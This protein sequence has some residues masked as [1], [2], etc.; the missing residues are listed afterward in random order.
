MRLD[1]YVARLDRR[2]IQAVRS[3]AAM[4][5]SRPV[6]TCCHWVNWLGDGWLYLFGMAMILGTDGIAAWRPLLAACLATGFAFVPYLL[7]KPS[8]RRLR[9]CDSDPA[10][11]RGA[12]ALDRYSCPSGHCMTLA[13]AA[14]PI[15][16]V[17]PSLTPVILLFG[18]LLAWTRLALGHHYPSDILVGTALGVTSGIAL[19]V[20]ML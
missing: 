9:P 14:I 10:L 2:E 16:W 17:H 4:S 15:A 6:I 20:A 18:L 5:S 13:A 12:R 11:S 3:V 7:L 8:L 1:E 19:T